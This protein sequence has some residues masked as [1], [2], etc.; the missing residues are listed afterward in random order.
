MP[1]SKLDT[2]YRSLVLSK[3]FTKGWGK[4]E[5]LKK[6][7]EFRKVVSERETCFQLVSQDYEVTITKE[8]SSSDGLLLEG[9]FVSPFDQYLPGLLPQV[10]KTAYF[11]VLLPKKWQSDHYK[12][13]CLHLAGTGDHF[14][15][16]RRNLMAKPLLKETGIGAILLENPFY[17]MRKPKDQVW[18]CLHNVSDIFVMGGCLIL[19]SLVL[20]HWCKRNGLGPFGVTGISMG[21]HMASLAATNWPE[22]IVLVPCLSWSTASAVFTRGVMSAAI[23]WELL[24]EQYFSDESYSKEIRHMVKIIENDTCYEAGQHFAKNYPESLEHV[25]KLTADNIKSST[26]NA[27]A[28][29]EKKSDPKAAEKN[30]S[31]DAQVNEDKENWNVAKKD[32]TAEENA[33]NESKSNDKAKNSGPSLDFISELGMNSI[34]KLAKS[35]MKMTNYWKNGDVKQ[36]NDENDTKDAKSRMKEKQALQF[37][38]GIMDECTH[39]TNFSVPVD[40]DLIIA[41]TARDDAYVPRDGLTDIRDIWRG[42]EVRYLN[43]GHVGAYLLHQKVFRTAIADAFNRMRSKYY[44]NEEKLKRNSSVPE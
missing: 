16:R 10:S 19:E 36:K 28:S 38:C 24:E 26:N 35:K 22:P 3:F 7:F 29:E 34:K 44:A 2:A 17:G 14:F 13:V 27:N 30:S 42:A 1:V 23:N 8:I 9:Q 31:G 18:S 32:K 37:M 6:L 11:Q 41:V 15:F 33:N 43:A 25:S 39:L 4:P 20:F 5:N 12:P 21:G 40:T